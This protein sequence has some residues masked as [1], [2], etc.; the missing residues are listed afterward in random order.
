M[1]DFFNIDAATTEHY[2]ER[3]AIREYDGRQSRTEAEAAAR[4]EAE[5]YRH[6]CEVREYARWDRDALVEQLRR[7]EAK[8]GRA[9][10]ERVRD[11]VVALR[12]SA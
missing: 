12:R 6:A 4:L 8:R 5:Q 10:A 7:I 1:T 9:A 3:A 11:D 2:E